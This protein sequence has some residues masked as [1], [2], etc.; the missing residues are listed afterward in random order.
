[1]RTSSKWSVDSIG[2]VIGV[3]ALTRFR[4]TLTAIRY[5]QVDSADWP[6]KFLSPRHARTNASCARSLASS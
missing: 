1:M 4:Q 6:L 5:S 3:F 2:S